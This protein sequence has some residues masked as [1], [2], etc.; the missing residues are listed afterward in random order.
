MSL[1]TIVANA[2]NKQNFLTIES[3]IEFCKT[4]LD[5]IE[6]GLQAVIISQNENQYCFYQ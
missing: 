3:Y 6:D 1:P 5:F 4:Y 2:V